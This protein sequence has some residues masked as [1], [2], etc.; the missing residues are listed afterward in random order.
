LRQLLRELI[1]LALKKMQQLLSA[2]FLGG[3]V[4]SMETWAVKLLLATL[5]HD[6]STHVIPTSVA[7]AHFVVCMKAFDVSVPFGRGFRL[8]AHLFSFIS[9]F[10]LFLLSFFFLLLCR[11]ILLE[12]MFVLIVTC[13][14]S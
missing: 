13:D 2:S 1:P 5:L 10:L 12:R 8:N 7:D 3:G 6:T 14:T 4:V 11:T 9:F